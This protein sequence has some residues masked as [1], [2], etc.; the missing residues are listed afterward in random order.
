MRFGKYHGLGNDFLITD[1][2]RGEP[3]G[4]PT[5]Q[6]AEMARRLCDRHFGV[7]C[8]GVI[9]VLPPRT[10]GAAAAMRVLNADGSEAEMCGNGL[11]CF[12]KFVVEL[13][14]S[15]G[16]APITVDTGAGPLTCQVTMKGGAVASVSVDMGR[17][18]ITRGEVPMTGPAGETCVEAPLMV[19]DRELRVTGVSMGNPHAV[20]FVPETGPA[21]LEL[22]RR[23]GPGLETHPWFPR[24]TNVDLAHVHGPDRIELV[25]WERG[26]GITLACGTGA[27]ATAVAASLTGRAP[28]GGE[29]TVGLLGG[30]LSIRVAPDL[31]GVVMRGPAEHVFDVDV[32]LGRFAVSRGRAA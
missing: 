4:E 2:R 7:G 26:C 29:V 5:V 6:D 16:S 8:D 18:R 17:P 27:S 19:G 25:V 30:D 20:F 13:E 31:G 9:A 1:L 24:K 23:I 32:E 21:L 12:V 22:A 15:L 28:A 14:P 10:S 11:R 3:A